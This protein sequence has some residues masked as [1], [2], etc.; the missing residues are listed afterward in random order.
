[1]GFGNDPKGLL[2]SLRK[3]KPG[4]LFINMRT[5]KNELTELKRQ[6]ALEKE[7]NYYLN[8]GIDAINRMLE[9][10]EIAEKENGRMMVKHNRTKLKI[11]YCQRH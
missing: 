9:L 5:I 3:P 10:R 8:I 7:I 2:L 6:L 4:L 1:L 11:T